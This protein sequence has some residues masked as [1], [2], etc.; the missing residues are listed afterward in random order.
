[1][2]L[3]KIKVLGIV[4]LLL[5]TTSCDKNFGTINT[6]PNGL[7]KVQ[8]KS[9]LAPAITKVVSYNMNRSQRITNELMQVT[10]NMGDGEGKIFRY[11]IRTSEADYLWNNW[12]LQIKNFKDVYKFAEDLDQKNY[13]GVSLIC[14]A[15]VFSMLTD[16]Y[17]DIP[18]YQA[19]QAQ[20]GNFMPKFDSQEEIYDQII[21]QLDK[22][23]N[24]LKNSANLDG[25]SDP[26]YGGNIQLWRKFANSLQLRLLLRISNKNVDKAS[27][28]INEIV[29]TNSTNY[30]LIENNT[31]S[32]ILKWTGVSP[33]VSPFNAWRNADWYTPKLAS[34]FVDNLN[35]A[36]DPR[37]QKWATAIDGEYQGIPSGYAIG[38][39]PT[40][41]STFPL[42]L[43]NDPLLG[44]ILN[45][46]EVQFIL[47]EAALKGWISSKSA[48]E[49]YENAA[50]EAIKL[51]GYEVPSD[52]L[53]REI[54]AW[55]DNDSFSKKMNQI[56]IQKYYS[57]FFTDLQ[58]WF[59][60]RRSGYP[61][62]P[63]GPGH[64]NNGIMPARLNYPVY[65]Q[66]SNKINYQ[67]AVRL[68]G[69]DNIN[70]LV[71]WQK[72]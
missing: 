15:W 68:Q 39:P 63:I 35:E 42:S 30:P 52:Y 1:M 21:Q 36:G 10:V 3:N 56:H 37:L 57:L 55:N 43:M 8:P 12:F 64:L 26:I 59:E 29:E 20:E 61:I 48:K 18:Y 34:F 5:A 17:G 38:N 50:T 28:K 44:N 62:L 72:P 23:N 69:P 33:Y 41:K 66:S 16:T 6:N 14:Q 2:N 51:W 11:E 53:N 54:I 22:A 45:Y 7:E 40:A 65:I 58:S 13:M 32:A 25:T 19:S 9:L 67:E 46:S 31:E 4:A 24:L 47:A 49:Y 70:T 27:Q 60:Y 71:W